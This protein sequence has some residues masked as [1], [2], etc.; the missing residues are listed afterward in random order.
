MVTICSGED[1]ATA[2]TLAAS[3]WP[4][5]ALEGQLAAVAER[6]GRAERT[7]TE[8]SERH[9]E[10]ARRLYAARCGIDYKSH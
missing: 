6:R 9:D 4:N 8:R 2:R 10:L 3:L 5:E 1:A 7:L